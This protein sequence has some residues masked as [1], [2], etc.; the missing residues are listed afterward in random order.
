MSTIPNDVREGIEASI[1]RGLQDEIQST[2]SERKYR[3]EY[4]ASLPAW[5]SKCHRQDYEY[6]PTYD[7]A[8]GSF[9]LPGG[10]IINVKAS[11]NLTAYDSSIKVSMHFKYWVKKDRRWAKADTLDHAIF[12]ATEL[13]RAEMI[14]HAKLALDAQEDEPA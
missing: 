5:I 13:T 9:S 12:C 6:D 14:E 2:T 8:S 11:W 7:I 3:E 4:F 1:T 10:E